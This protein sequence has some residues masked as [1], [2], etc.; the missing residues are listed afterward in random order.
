[1]LEALP[2]S[3]P[4]AVLEVVEQLEGTLIGL[5]GRRSDCFKSCSANSLLP[6]RAAPVT[7]IA[8]PILTKK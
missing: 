8:C 6:D 5:I 3:V 1:M 2:E 7:R 4:E